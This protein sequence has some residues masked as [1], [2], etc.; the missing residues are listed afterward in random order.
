MMQ[1]WLEAQCILYSKVL[2]FT[3]WPA[4]ESNHH[5]YKMYSTINKL[6][7]S[8]ASKFFIFKRGTTAHWKNQQARRRRHHQCQSSEQV[9]AL[10]QQWSVKYH[11][12]QDNLCLYLSCV[13]ACAR[14]QFLARLSITWARFT[15]TKNKSNI[16]SLPPF[17]RH[18]A[19]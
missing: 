10:K 11:Q 15:W 5:V 7:A 9:Q 17:Q 3:S 4:T 12:V 19:Q 13:R 1:T 16:L 14:L 8:L 18:G 6:H 2:P